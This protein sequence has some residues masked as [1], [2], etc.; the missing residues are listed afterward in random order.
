MAE[1][2]LRT[3]LSELATL[4]E[5]VE[6][7]AGQALLPVEVAFQLGLVLEEL[8][9]NAIGHGGAQGAIELRVERRGDTVEVEMVDAG[10]AFDPR[11]LPAP[12][13]AAPLEQRQVGGLGVFLVRQFID[14]IEYRREADRNHLR[15]RKRLNSRRNSGA[16]AQRG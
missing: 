13:L 4:A 6:R 2:T 14:E 10:A 15:L 12:D 3:E 7:F 5:F 16:G 9:A 11:T 1:I 8:V